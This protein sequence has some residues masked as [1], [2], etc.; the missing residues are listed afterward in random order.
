M[1]FVSPKSNRGPVTM[2]KDVLLSCIALMVFVLHVK[3]DTQVRTWK[4]LVN[5]SWPRSPQHACDMCM[6]STCL[7]HPFSIT[8]LYKGQHAH[9]TQTKT[10]RSSS[11]CKRSQD[12]IHFFE[13]TGIWNVNTKKPKEDLKVAALSL[14]SL[15]HVMGANRKENWCF[16]CTEQHH[17]D[18]FCL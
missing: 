11:I 5:T 6:A 4:W 15:C 17:A 2:S 3:G 9:Q 1:P 18:S 10:V 7:R 12:K 14:L 8:V 16:W 13:R